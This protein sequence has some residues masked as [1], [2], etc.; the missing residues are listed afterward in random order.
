MNEPRDTP[1]SVAAAGRRLAAAREG[2]RD[3][4]LQQS[5]E[6]L[7]ALLDRW[8]DPDSGVRRELAA[9]LP[10]ATGMHPATVREGLQR[11]LEHFSGRA[12]RE[13]VARDLPWL[14]RP[15]RALER[16]R[17]G[18]F[19]QTSV[20]L[21]GS[22]PMPSLLSLLLPLIVHSPVLAK[23]ASRDPV[24]AR[25]FRASL[26]ELDPELAGC[27]EVVSFKGDDEACTEA[28]LDTDCLVASGSDE[29]IA[30]LRAR[31]RPATRLVAYGHRL[32]LIAVGSQALH[33]SGLE[34][35][36]ERLALDIA[37]WDQLGCLSP[38][39][40][41]C[42]SPD[43]D[44]ADTLAAAL[45]RCLEAAERRWPRGDVPDDARAAIRRGRDEALMRKA[46]GRDVTLWA[47]S[48]TRW[49]VV[50]EDDLAWRPAPLYRFVRVQPARDRSSLLSAISNVSAHLAAVAMAGF[51]SE[52]P[53]VACRVAALGASRI[54]APGS[55]Q[56]P[57]LGW[58][59]N[60]QSPLHPFLRFSDIELPD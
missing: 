7:C 60:G 17:A 3:R 38:V 1:A 24:T 15:Q 25:L 16:T 12:L 44:A 55:M 19:E 32:S 42:E 18:G 9:E 34:T 6:S 31:L 56:T 5:L 11:A 36:A 39:S 29:T 47:D 23:T 4:P 37:L 30:A 57:P 50:C 43:R 48:G 49:T 45:S 59:H 51:G 40:V 21:A 33:G 14:E 26:A 41:L 58:H 52:T 20:L 27:V 2:L 10:K 28:F 8:Q 53:E 35:L 13:L 54:C 22:I 46:A